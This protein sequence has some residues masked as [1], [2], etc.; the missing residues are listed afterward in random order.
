MDKH[1]EA[2]REEALE[3][4]TELEAALLDLEKTPDDSDL[5]GRVFRAMHTIKGSGAMFGF[6]DV[7][8]FTHDIETVYDRVRNGELAVDGNVISLTLS[9]C[10]RIR[11]M[12]AAPGESSPEEEAAA[13]GIRAFFKGL[14]AATGDRGPAAAPSPCVDG[15]TVQPGQD[16]EEITYRIRFRPARNIFASGTN[17]VLLLKELAGLG[18]CAITAH[19]GDIPSLAEIDPEGCYTSWDVILT[20]RQDMN[21][22]RDVFI[23]AED[24]CEVT[25]AVI[26]GGGGGDADTDY[27]KIGEILV[28]RGDINAADV[29]GILSSQKRI[30]EMLVDSGVVTQETVQSA[31]AEQQHVREVRKERKSAEAMTSL[32]VPAEKLDT[33]VNLV[34]ELVTVQSRLNQV[35]STLN[36]P[37]LIPVA[38]EVERL[39]DELREN[40]MNIRMLPIGTTFSKFNRLVRDLSSELRKEI[41][42]VTAGGETELDKT[43][44]ERLNDPLIHIIRNSI[45]HGI[46]E[47][48]V[49][50]AAGKPR[51]GTIRLSAEHAGANVLIKV[52]DDGAGLNAE[53]IRAK[54]VEK[55]LLVPDASA[56]E[57]EL[58]PLIFA[59]GFS[60]AGKITS[61]S[62]RGVG[63]DVVRKGIDALRGSIDVESR[64]GEGTTMTLKLPLTLAIIDGL[65]VAVGEDRFVLPL[66]CI[67]ECVEM[68]REKAAEPRGR[69]ITRVR[70]DIVPYIRLR[71][72]FGSPGEP[73]AREQIIMTSAEGCRVGIVVDE[74]I[75]EHQTVI[76]SLGRFYRDAK[77][78]SGATILGDG[79]VALI[80][81]VPQLVQ[82]TEAA[83]RAF[84]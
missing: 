76:K 34:G 42:L 33:L 64:S 62:G 6:E 25:V 75:G 11:R 8:S 81:D 5:V 37:E 84:S 27:K 18:R 26:D 78:V 72:C 59:P 69:R 17:P 73:P 4:L 74:V 77:D 66:H 70:G 23:F 35:A 57:K 49:R 22:I 56:G 14:S 10:D 41:M 16:G 58:F 51:Q 68:T 9:A 15:P 28:D 50:E 52:S 36:A 54:A 1:R 48:A 39:T 47:P 40:A 53:A 2:F 83:E 55:G 65:L 63:L 80:V 19:T 20:T 79:T 45:D 61:V 30:G 29:A 24:Y 44:I 43:V 3:L 13:E 21:A 38:E 60:T 46:E 32:R 82:G 67:E 31:L 7:A 71:E 12:V